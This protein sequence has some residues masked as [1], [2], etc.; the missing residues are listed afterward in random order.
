MMDGLSAVGA[1]DQRS[2]AAEIVDKKLEEGIYG[3]CLV[4]VSYRVEKLCRVERYHAREGGD[5]VDG[6]P[7]VC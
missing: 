7:T 2:L 1:D 5:G 3:E 6:H 4:D